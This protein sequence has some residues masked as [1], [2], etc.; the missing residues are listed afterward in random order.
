MGVKLWK[1][2]DSMAPSFFFSGSSQTKLDEKN[3]FVLPQEMRYGLIEQGVLE[4]SLALGLGGCIAMYRRSDME[5]IV[6]Q[7]RRKQNVGKYQKFF[8]LFFSTLYHTSCDK[9]GRIV[10]PP[11]LKKAVG[12]T[13]EIVIAGVLNR[14]EIWPQNRFDA[15]FDSILSGKSE[16]GAFHNI[17][18]EAFGLLDEQEIRSQQAT[19]TSPS[20]TFLQRVISKEEDGTL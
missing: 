1:K 12:I 13:K 20:G 19:S 10:L 15:Q 8:T 17:I 6:E 16:E 14:I 7:F 5:K 11:A 18:E 3:R 9:L 2:V 4:A